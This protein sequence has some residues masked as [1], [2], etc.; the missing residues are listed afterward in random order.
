MNHPPHERIFIMQITSKK[1]S[2]DALIFSQI[3][4]ILVMQGTGQIHYGLSPSTPHQ[5]IS[6]LYNLNFRNSR[7][8]RLTPSA[9]RQIIHRMKKN[10]D[11]WDRLKKYALSQFSSEQSKI[12]AHQ[13]FVQ[14]KT[15]FRGYT[16]EEIRPSS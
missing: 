13:Q 12:H 8:G 4:D 10:A 15:D 9:L 2:N 14:F 1:E 5:L 6:L 11:E 3:I 7:G 16:D